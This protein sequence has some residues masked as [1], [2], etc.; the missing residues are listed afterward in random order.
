MG[1]L[2]DRQGGSGQGRGRL[3]VGVGPTGEA[4]LLCLVHAAAE[5]SQ[6]HR[7]CNYMSS[8]AVQGRTAR[9]AQHGKAWHGMGR[10]NKSGT[11]TKEQRG[12]AGSAHNDAEQ[13][14]EAQKRHITVQHAQ[15]SIT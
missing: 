3:R 11:L 9:H 8:E 10:Q 7:G 12:T 14:R 1:M 15:Q 4:E 13:H 2:Q 5:G 6:E